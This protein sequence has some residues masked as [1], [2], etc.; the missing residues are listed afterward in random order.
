MKMVFPAG[1]KRTEAVQKT[2]GVGKEAQ[3]V[4]VDDLDAQFNAIKGLPGFEKQVADIEQCEGDAVK[5]VADLADKAKEAIDE[6]VDKAKEVVQVSEADGKAEKKEEKPAE[7]PDGKKDEKD[8]TVEVEVA[9]DDKPPDAVE[10]EVKDDGTV[11]IPG[12]KGADGVKKESE[13]CVAKAVDKTE[14]EAVK[15]KPEKSDKPEK[16][17]AKEPQFVKI[18]MLSPENRAELETYWKTI[19]PPEYVD[20]MLKNYETK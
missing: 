9:V 15:D 11:D 8:D 4:V 1:G 13:G 6:V 2:E 18:S 10:I 5:E 3:A 19:F 17:A 7:K 16:E 20:A 14:K 12:I